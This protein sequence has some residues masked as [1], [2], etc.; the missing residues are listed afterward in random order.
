MAG[1]DY[2]PFALRTQPECSTVVIYLI[3]NQRDKSNL[4]EDSINFA[5]TPPGHGSRTLLSYLHMAGTCALHRGAR[6]ARHSC[7]TPYSVRPS[8]MDNHKHIK[9]M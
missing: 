9:T 4:S 6:L 8:D 3:Y 5:A 1:D 7:H 2:I